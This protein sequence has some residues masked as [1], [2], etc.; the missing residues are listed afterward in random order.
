[1]HVATKFIIPVMVFFHFFNSFFDKMNFDFDFWGLHNKSQNYTTA[2]LQT[3]LTLNEPWRKRAFCALNSR[4]CSPLSPI[5]AFVNLWALTWNCVGLSML[6]WWAFVLD[7]IC[8]IIKASCV[9]STFCL[10]FKHLEIPRSP[11]NQ[12]GVELL[13]RAIPTVTCRGRQERKSPVWM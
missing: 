10:R 5:G 8:S 7:F 9:N 11:P 12:T 6:Q 4:K 13:F 3:F 1:M 2:Q